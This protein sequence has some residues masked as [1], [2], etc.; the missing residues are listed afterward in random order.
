[1]G[2]PLNDSSF[3]G[4]VLK[5]MEGEGLRLSEISYGP[6][7]KNSP[8][9]HE[10]AY[11]CVTL[12]GNATQFCDGRVRS[13]KP[14]T[15]MYH[16]AGEVHSDQFHDWGARELNIEMAPWRLANLR[17]RSP[18]AD[19]GVDVNGGKPEWLAT[20]LYGEFRL[21][22]ELS[23]M[24][25]E[26]LTLELMAEMLR[27]SSRGGVTRIPLWLR[28]AQDLIHERFLDRLTLS[29]LAQ[30]VGVH[31]VHF[32]REFH[33]HVGCTLGQRVRRLRIER[34]CSLLNQT[35]APLAEIALNTG[36]SDQSQFSKTFRAVTGVTPSEYRQFKSSR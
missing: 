24:A 4:K 26:G 3:H 21:M 15:V 13:A 30:T 28:Q 18:Y 7:L 23:P 1:M 12:N 34:A 22:D 14:W 5:R 11:L 17:R 9:S 27:Q 33:R 35:K 16:P 2:L 36:F 32:A 8:H 29:D 10:Y 25:I 6:N 31:P 19:S 20:R